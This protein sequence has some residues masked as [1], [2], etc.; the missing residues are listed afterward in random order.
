MFDEVKS[1]LDIRTVLEYYGAEFNSRGFAKCVLHNEKT[2]SLSTK[3][4]FFKCFG[5]GEGGSTIDFVM[6]MFNLTNVEAAKKLN[7]DFN[8]NLTKSAPEIRLKTAERQREL[9]RIK[10]FK[11]WEKQTFRVL[12][13]YF[14]ILRFWGEQIFID[15]REYFNKYLP[16]VENIVFVETMLDSI[17]LNTSDFNAQVEFYKN[18]GEECDKI[19]KRWAEINE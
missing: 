3:N 1:R 16:D 4:N 18:Y 13:D 14:K 9:N 11:Q 10:E 5:C 19:A 17:I 2:A 8:L 7:D 12:S 6:K 15:N